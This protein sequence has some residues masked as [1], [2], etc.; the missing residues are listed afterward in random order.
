M[1][2]R[3]GIHLS[4]KNVFILKHS[5][6]QRI[7][8]EKEILDVCEAGPH[9]LTDEELIKL[10]KYHNEHVKCLNA[11]I[12]EINH[13]GWVYCDKKNVFEKNIPIQGIRRW[14]LW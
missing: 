4:Y 7:S 14:I 9:D 2:K 3:F 10:K 6:E 13:A 5:L 12:D 11:V 8:C 1:S